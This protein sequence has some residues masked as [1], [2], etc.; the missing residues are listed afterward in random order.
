[1]MVLSRSI[2][3]WTRAKRGTPFLKRIEKTATSRAMAVKI[4]GA[5]RKALATA[6]HHRS[7]QEKEWRPNDGAQGGKDD[8]LELGHLRSLPK[9]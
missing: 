8:V 6:R 3:S 5:K 9:F 4:K 1:M 2:F 7:P